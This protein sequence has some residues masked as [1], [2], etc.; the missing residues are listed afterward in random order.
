MISLRKSECGEE[1]LKK[2][3]LILPVTNYQL[4]DTDYKQLVLTHNIK[5]GTINKQA[6]MQGTA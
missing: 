2:L 6:F 3:I 5:K 1:I 4:T